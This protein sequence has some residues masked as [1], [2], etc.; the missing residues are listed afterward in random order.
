MSKANAEFSKFNAAMGAILRADPAKVKAEME[1]DKAANAEKRK[2][3]KRPSALGRV[4]S[5]KG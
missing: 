2:T 1:A 3:K 4:S 5:G